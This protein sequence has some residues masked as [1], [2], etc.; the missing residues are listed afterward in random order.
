[1]QTFFLSFKDGQL[2]W[3]LS[4]EIILCAVI[5]LNRCVVLYYAMLCYHCYAYVIHMPHYFCYATLFF[6][7]CYVYA[8]LSQ[9]MLMPHFFYAPAM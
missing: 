3:H 1:M 8:M 5:F 6:M 7:L 2:Y 4:S 9:V